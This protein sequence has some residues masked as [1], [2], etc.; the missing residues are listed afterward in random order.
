MPPLR[1]SFPGSSALSHA[2]YDPD[3]QTLTV[4]FKNGSQSYTYPNVPPDV[5]EQLVSA[6]SPGAFW[7]GSIKDQF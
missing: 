2:T 3:I 6:D 7:R 5:Y 1:Q 4:T